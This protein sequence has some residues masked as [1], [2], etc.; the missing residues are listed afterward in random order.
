MPS[1][2]L[3]DNE[4]LVKKGKA[5]LQNR[6]ARELKWAGLDLVRNCENRPEIRNWPWNKAPLAR[7]TEILTDNGWKRVDQIEIGEFVLT[8]R[9]QDGLMEWH[10]VEAIPRHYAEKLLHF[11]NK[12]IDQLVT[13]EH[14][15]VCVR[16]PNPQDNNSII[17]MEAKALWDVVGYRIPL[18]GEW[19]GKHPPTL[20]GLHSGDVMELIGWYVAEGWSSNVKGRKVGSLFIGQSKTANPKKCA[21][22]EKLFTRLGISFQYSKEGGPSKAYTL[23]A[24]TMPKGLA[25]LLREQGLC[26]EKHIPYFCF[27]FSKGLISRLLYGMI[28]G[29]GSRHKLP[30]Q[31]LECVSIG[32]TSKRLADGLQLLALLS[33]KRGT[34][35]CEDKRGKVVGTGSGGIARHIFYRV[36]INHKPFAKINKDCKH[37]IV[38]YNDFAYCVTVKNHAIYVRRNGIASWTGNSNIEVP[39]ADMAVTDWKAVLTADVIRGRQLAN[40]KAIRQELM[41]LQAKAGSYHDQLIRNHTNYIPQ[42]KFA[43]DDFGHGGFSYMKVTWDF[44]R[45]VPRFT[46]LGFLYI[47]RPSNSQLLEDDDLIFHVIQLSKASVKRRWGHIDGVEELLRD[48]SESEPEADHDQANT[49]DNLYKRVGIDRSAYGE[50]KKMVF[51][52]AHYRKN[53][54]KGNERLRTVSPDRLELELEDDQEYPYDYCREHGK[55][56]IVEGLREYKHPKAYSSRGLTELSVDTQTTES[57][58]RRTVQNLLTLSQAPMWQPAKDA[59]GNTGNFTFNPGAYSPNRVEYVPTPEIRA[60][61]FNEIREMQ[62]LN[63]QIVKKPDFSLAKQQGP[64]GGKDPRTATEMQFAQATQNIASDLVLSNWGDFRTEIARLS[65]GLC[66]QYKPKS[67]TMAFAGEATQLE[68]EALSNDFIISVATDSEMLNREMQKGIALQTLQLFRGSQNIDQPKLERN[69]LTVVQPEWVQELWI[70]PAEATGQAMKKAVLEVETMLVTGQPQPIN[71]TDDHNACSVVAFK[72][73][74]NQAEVQ[75]MQPEQAAMILAW[76]QQHAQIL[77][78]QNPQ[79]GE[80]AMAQLTQLGEVLPSVMQQMHS[81]QGQGMNGATGGANGERKPPSLSIGFKDLPPGGQVQAAA[82]AGI[83]ISPEEIAAQ[84]VME[85]QKQRAMKPEPVNGAREN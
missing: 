30:H 3:P 8:R 70:E 18:T 64:Q 46:K 27:G 82:M 63:E 20:F 45:G 4:E 14:T 55:Y 31:N 2:G 74:T 42:I 21:H 54:K 62:T 83:Q 85:V 60:E 28:E 67:M 10:S 13:P 17:R 34:I 32:T 29:D 61:W 69:V 48:F 23:H 15:M 43:A 35:S 80:Q 51:W 79:A 56:M 68:A 50:D 58:A 9:D 22:L 24:K 53:G 72:Y 59:P 41:P 39:R 47:I 81:G 7:D 37:K 5:A 16:A 84:D 33:G 1:D 25:D 52:Q 36:Q 44:D 76:G 40:F 66:V 49:E 65:W 38:D 77:A 11:K 71:P 57:A 78:K 19:G 6:M 75:D 26:F 73:L 12:S